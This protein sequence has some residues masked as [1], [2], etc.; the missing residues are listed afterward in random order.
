MQE[1]PMHEVTALS[2]KSVNS[3]AILGVGNHNVTVAE[4]VTAYP[5]SGA[6][7][8]P[9]PQLKVLFKSNEDGKQFTEWY[10]TRGYVRFNELAKAD[11]ESGRFSSQEGYAIDKST[12]ARIIDVKRTE[13]ALS[14]IG[15]LGC[16]AGIALN[17]D[18]VPTDLIGKKLTIIVGTDDRMN[19]RVKSTRKESKVTS[20]VF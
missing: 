19:L 15:K 7:A 3:G 12:G 2:F 4:V 18:F 10:N 13:Q 1:I 20:E 11:L 17:T 6:F 8:D 9:T 16:D 14:I 5:K